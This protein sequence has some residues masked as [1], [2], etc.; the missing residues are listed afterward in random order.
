M[1]GT[2]RRDSETGTWAER[3][4]LGLSVLIVVAL[5]V[6]IVVIDGS[7]GNARPHITADPQFGD[8]YE[9]SGTWYLPVTFTNDGG[10]AVETLRVDMVLEPASGGEPEVSDME[11][12]FVA[13]GEQVRGTAAFDEEPTPD[14]VRSD[15]VSVTEP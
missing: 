13:A 5:V 14:A 3:I 1:V 8:A 6:G 15:V 2:R 4:T 7:T 11:F 9:R 10:E 12:S